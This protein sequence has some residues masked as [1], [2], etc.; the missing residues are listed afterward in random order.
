L[1]KVTGANVSDK[2]ILEYDGFKEHFTQSKEINEYNYNSYMKPEDIERQKVL[3]SYGYK[4]LRINRFNVG[5][6]P[7]A[8]LDKGLWSLLQ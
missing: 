4:F 1:L 7:V 3:E 2:I 8:Y 5:K 6:D